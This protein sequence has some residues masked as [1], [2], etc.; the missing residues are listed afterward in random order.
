MTWYNCDRFQ[1]IG[2]KTANVISVIG[3]FGENV[4]GSIQA[5]QHRHG[6]AAVVNLTC[7]DLK[8]KWISQ[9][10]HTCMDFTG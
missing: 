8:T 9:S 1:I 5:L 7:A 4:S 6:I 3:H 10:I 2:N